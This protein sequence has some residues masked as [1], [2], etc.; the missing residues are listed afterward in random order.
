MNKEKLIPTNFKIELDPSVSS[1]DEK[2]LSAWEEKLEQ[3]S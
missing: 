3:F 2:S 1:H